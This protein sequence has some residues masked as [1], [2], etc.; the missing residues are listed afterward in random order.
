MQMEHLSQEA[1]A[2]KVRYRTLEEM[3]RI[4]H[5][6]RILTAH[7][8]DD[9]G[10]TFLMRFLQS[11]DWWEWTSIPARRGNILR[12]LLTLRRQQIRDYAL[13]AGLSWRDDPSNEEI[14]HLRNF[15]RLRVLP[16]FSENGQSVNLPAL[17]EAGDR[18][19]DIVDDILNEADKFVQE[20]RDKHQEMVLAI[21]DIL[22]YFNMI[23]W[24]P[25]ERAVAAMLWD[26]NFRWPAWRRRQVSDFIVARASRGLLHLE[27][28][29]ILLR[30]GQWLAL[31]TQPPESISRFLRECGSHSLDG[32]GEIELSIGANNGIM[33]RGD[34][35]HASA[36]LLDKGLQIRTWQPGDR[37]NIFR[38]GHRKISDL[39]NELRLDPI[40][41]QNAL[42]LCDEEGPFW[43][44]GHWSDHRARPSPDDKLVLELKWRK[45]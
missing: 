38:R 41:R 19:R 17:A 24:A 16:Q 43:L 9:S 8:A 12:P 40:S 1:A 23:C 18:I 7:T 10:E 36:A 2:R 20:Q 32:L 21:P 34:R 15:L 33:S 11:P 45:L 4:W 13:Q 25:A 35:I 44:V 39:L 3:A 30:Q 6:D 31:I 42:V 29:A 5:C 26:S 14:R 37:L 22:S 27:K 28:G